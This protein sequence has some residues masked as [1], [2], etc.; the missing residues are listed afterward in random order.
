M[1]NNVMVVIYKCASLLSGTGLCWM[2]YSLFLKGITKSAGDF[3]GEYKDAK[4]T[5][6]NGA[7]GLYFAILGTVV[8]GLTL[9]RGVKLESLLI[10]ENKQLEQLQQKLTNNDE[11]TLATATKLNQLAQNYKGISTQVITMST[12]LSATKLPETF[13]LPK[14]EPRNF[15]DIKPVPKDLLDRLNSSESIPK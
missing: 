5:L 10:T 14:L 2:G 11:A 9:Y 4:V 13:N 8:L 7:P 6:R 15:S 1:D 12:T 3:D